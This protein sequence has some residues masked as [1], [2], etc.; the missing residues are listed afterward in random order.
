MFTPIYGNHI[1]IVVNQRPDPENRGRIQVYIPHISPSITWNTEQK[2]KEFATVDDSIFSSENLTLLNRILPW[3]ECASP[4][5]GGS[6]PLHVNLQ[7]GMS[8]T[9]PNQTI[10]PS[11]SS[12][13]PKTY[14]KDAG[15]GNA[16]IAL[17]AAANDDATANNCGRGVANVLKAQ[18]LP[19]REDEN[20]HAY[21]WIDWFSSDQAVQKDN[22]GKV[23]GRWLKVE[24]ATAETA[25]ENAVNVFN[26]TPGGN[27]NKGAEFGHIEQ[28]VYDPS[29]GKKV[30]VSDKSRDNSGGSVPQN[31]AG[32]WVYKEG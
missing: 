24:G 20:R 1:G 32:S 3:A 30:Y 23:I 21:T 14:N 29:S 10:S 19:S 6:T 18:G 7:S 11:V 22:N 15:K 26:R 31:Y 13:A 4:V 16:E 28:V 27:N 5:F 2:N 12:N 9:N 17:S 25:P 8:S